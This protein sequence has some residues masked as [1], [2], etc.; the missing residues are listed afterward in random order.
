MK[1]VGI[2][3]SDHR[4]K[5]IDMKAFISSHVVVMLCE[6]VNE[7]CPIVPFGIQNVQWDIPDPTPKNGEHGGIEKFRIARDLI[8]EKVIQL[9]KEHDVLFG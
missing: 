1:E 5:R 4:S 3:I 8:K 7:K 9:L 6:Q 2:D